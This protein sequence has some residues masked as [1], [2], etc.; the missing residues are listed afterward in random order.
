MA[1]LVSLAWFAGMAGIAYFL[2]T[3]LA[4]AHQDAL[5]RQAEIDKKEA[6]AE[7]LRAQA[8]NEVIKT[9]PDRRQPQSQ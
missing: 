6:E 9:I 1:A 5:E 3:G 7:L 2:I 4:K 8:L